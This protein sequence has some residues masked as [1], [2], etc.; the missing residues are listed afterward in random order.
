MSQSTPPDE[1][2]IYEGGAISQPTIPPP[3][4]VPIVERGEA[5][6]AKARGQ[7]RHCVDDYY[8]PH[9][10]RTLLVALAAGV[11]IGLAMDVD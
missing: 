3:G 8:K 5:A 6:L 2:M 7:L 4:E 1:D 9:P 10:Y 11:L